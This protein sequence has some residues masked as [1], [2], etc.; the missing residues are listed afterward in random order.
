M[1]NKDINKNE[2]NDYDLMGVTGGLDIKNQSRLKPTLLYGGIQAF[3]PPLSNFEIIKQLEAFDKDAKIS[4]I[5]GTCNSDLAS[6]LSSLQP[7][8]TVKEAIKF[9]CRR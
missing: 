4:D 6:S 7:N 2:L 9:F 8:M 3:D 1:A 5:I